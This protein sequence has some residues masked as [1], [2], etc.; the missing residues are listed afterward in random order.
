MDLEKEK[1][2]LERFP[3][4]VRPILAG[5]LVSLGVGAISVCLLLLSISVKTVPMR[6]IF[7]F[8][9]MIIGFFAGVIGYIVMENEV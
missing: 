7:M 9:F 6:P 1:I 8:V 3:G 4:F 2:F 5:L